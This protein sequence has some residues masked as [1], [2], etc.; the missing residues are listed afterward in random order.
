MSR[1]EDSCE[2]LSSVENSPCGSLGSDGEGAFFPS[3]FHHWPN[4]WPMWSYSRNLQ[5]LPVLYDS[6]A[7]T[8]VNVHVLDLKGESVSLLL[9]PALNVSKPA[10][11]TVISEQ[12]KKDFI[13]FLFLQQQAQSQDSYV[14]CR[15]INPNYIRKYP[16]I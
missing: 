4:S 15:Q 14:C 7:D 16:D 6:K 10:A 9:D 12:N 11:T 8:C 2:D 3:L 13:L 5:C 1:S